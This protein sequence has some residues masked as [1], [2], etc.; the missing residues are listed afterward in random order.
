MCMCKFETSVLLSP[1]PPNLVLPFFED[2]CP[3][4]CNTLQ[5]GRRHSRALLPARLLDAKAPKIT[6]V[7][8]TPVRTS[9][10]IYPFTEC[11]VYIQIVPVIP[12][13]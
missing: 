9:D 1:P 7:I 12:N 2:C 6:T 5:S 13:V 11:I 8:I 3:V 4:G 10:V